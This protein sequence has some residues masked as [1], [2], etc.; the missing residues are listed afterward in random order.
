MGVKDLGDAAAPIRA[1]TYGPTI[2][3]HDLISC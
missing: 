3:L 2:S 1:I